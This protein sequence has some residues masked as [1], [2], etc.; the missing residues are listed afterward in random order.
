MKNPAGLIASSG[1]TR[2]RKETFYYSFAQ[3][4]VRYCVLSSPVQT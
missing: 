4:Y 2:A 3:S 1:S